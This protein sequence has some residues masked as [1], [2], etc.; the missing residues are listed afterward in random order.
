[1]ELAREQFDA[2]Y[3]LAEEQNDQAEAAYLEQ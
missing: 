2:N 1:M 3:K